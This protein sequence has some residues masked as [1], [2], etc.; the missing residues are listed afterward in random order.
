MKDKNINLQGK[1]E[2]ENCFT[3]QYIRL[4]LAENDS[5][6]IYSLFYIYMTVKYSLHKKIAAYKWNMDIYGEFLSLT[7]KE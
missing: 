6:K 2:A 1:H 3:L 7:V 4:D 5:H